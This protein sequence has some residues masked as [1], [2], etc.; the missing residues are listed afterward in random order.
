MLGAEVAAVTTMVA[1]NTRLVMVDATPAVM[2]RLI[3][4]GHTSVRM[5]GMVATNSI[6]LP[7]ARQTCPALL[8]LGF[9]S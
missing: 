4:A 1:G 8:N 6:R 3:A 5:A 2:A 7:A 9:R